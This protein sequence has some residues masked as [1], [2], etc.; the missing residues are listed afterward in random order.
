M[1]YKAHRYVSNDRCLSVYEAKEHYIKNAS[2]D[3]LAHE[4][5]SDKTTVDVPRVET[6]DDA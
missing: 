4:P 1:I 6:S 5:S 3:I 2:S